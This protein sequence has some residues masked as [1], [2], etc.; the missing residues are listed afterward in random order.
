MADTPKKPRKKTR[1]GRSLLK[2]G[3]VAI[4]VIKKDEATGKMRGLTEAEKREARTTALPTAGREKMGGD[5]IT[6]GV[7][8]RTTPVTGRSIVETPKRGFARNPQQVGGLLKQAIGHLEKMKETHGTPDFHGH[9]DTFNQVHAAL[10]VDRSVHQMLGIARSA[11]LNPTHPQSQ[12]HFDLSMKALRSK[13]SQGTSVAAQNVENAR[14][15][16]AA[17]RAKRIAAQKEGNS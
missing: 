9:H 2:S 12:T 11:I 3:K 13:L 5:P 10:G 8:R 15:G 4:P 1:T 14:A 17:A 7:N 16:Q 6:V